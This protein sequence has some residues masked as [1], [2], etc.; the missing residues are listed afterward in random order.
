MTTE[1]VYFY[2]QEWD[3]LYLGCDDA[4]KAI[5]E[6]KFNFSLKLSE[7]RSMSLALV[8]GEEA[9]VVFPSASSIAGKHE[10]NFRGIILKSS[11]LEVRLWCKFI[12]VQAHGSTIA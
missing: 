8:R 11:S 10:T 12:S 7:S 2:E 5:S 6:S 4:I 1:G 3:E 9:L